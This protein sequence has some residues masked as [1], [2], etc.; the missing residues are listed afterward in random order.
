MARTPKPKP[1][2][3]KKAA[4]KKAA[5][6]KK[7]TPKQPRAKKVP[8]LPVTM[9]ARRDA[10]LDSL[11][12]RERAFF[13]RYI[14]HHNAR[15]AYQE[16]YGCAT[17][18]AYN[19]GALLAKRKDMRELLKLHFREAMGRS[20]FGEDQ[21]AAR[22]WQTATAS[23]TEVVQQRRPPC[24]YCYGIDHEYQWTTQREF[25]EAM[26]RA[27]HNATAGMTL[28]DAT[29][30][31][32]ALKDGIYADPNIPTDL[33]GFGYDKIMP[34]NDD[35]PECR[36]IGGKPI[37]TV[38]DSDLFTPEAEL[39]FD[40]VKETRDG[41]EVKLTDR[42]RALD[43]LAKHLGMFKGKEDSEIFDPFKAWMERVAAEA[44]P[45]PVTPCE[46]P[47]PTAAPIHPTTDTHD[48]EKPKKAPKKAKKEAKKA[49][50]PPTDEDDGYVEP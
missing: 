22:Y 46:S 37:L 50:P 1:A 33:G 42:F 39:L 16:A 44:K 32:A 28:E 13:E 18:T 36:G 12:L 41:I 48:D 6:S 5:A 11:K 29:A 40:G 25:R 14:I 7:P 2:P 34:P 31:Q 20:G 45:I 19:S 17:T 49:P 27:L 24:R 8:P 21:V 15:R 35:C 4:P 3:K 38:T 43:N 26:D 10:L 30:M 23:V 9:A 47:Q